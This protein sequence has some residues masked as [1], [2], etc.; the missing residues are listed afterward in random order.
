MVAIAP[1]SLSRLSALKCSVFGKNSF[2][3]WDRTREI[4]LESGTLS[5]L[6]AFEAN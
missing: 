5:I 3:K 2:Q 4:S 6:A 1:K